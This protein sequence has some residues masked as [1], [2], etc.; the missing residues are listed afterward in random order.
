MKVSKRFALT[1]AEFGSFL[2][3]E[4]QDNSTVEAHVSGFFLSYFYLKVQVRKI[5]N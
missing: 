5:T 2:H 4:L 3:K 1:S